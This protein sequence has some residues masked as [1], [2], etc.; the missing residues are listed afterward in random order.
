MF[1][2]KMK[3]LS[4]TFFTLLLLFGTLN[5]INCHKMKKNSDSN[6]WNKENFNS[7]FEKSEQNKL[8]K[9]GHDLIKDI[10]L[11]TYDPFSI[12]HNSNT[13][14]IQ[15]KHT[16]ISPK[17]PWTNIK[18]YFDYYHLNQS[19]DRKEITE[20]QHK[21]IYNVME[22]SLNVISE[23]VQVQS[24]NVRIFPQQYMTD[25]K[26]NPDIITNGVM[27]DLAICVSAIKSHSMAYAYATTLLNGNYRPLT[28]AVVWN[29]DIF[30]RDN[31]LEF[32][33]VNTALHELLHVMGFNYQLF[34]YFVDE[35]WQFLPI[36]KIVKKNAKGKD[37]IITPR[38]VEATR[39]HY[40]CSTIE[41]LELEDDGGSGTVGS[42]WEERIMSGEVMNGMD[43]KEAAL[44]EMT[45]ALLEDSGWYKTKKFT[46]G[47]FMFGRK[48][49]CEFLQ[50]KCVTEHGT[51]FKNE[52]CLTKN[53]SGCS[54]NRRWKSQCHLQEKDASSVANDELHFH[55][56]DNQ[57]KTV[58]LGSSRAFSDNCPVGTIFSYPHDSLY[59]SCSRGKID[60]FWNGPVSNYER[61]SNNG[62][63][64]I[65]NVRDKMYS[66]FYSGHSPYI[67][68]CYDFKCDF[69]KKTINLQINLKSFECP[70][71]GGI[72]DID[73]PNI[74]GNIV[75]PDFY[76]LC[77]QTEKCDS[78]LECVNKKSLR[79]EEPEILNM[80]S[81]ANMGSTLDKNMKIKKVKGY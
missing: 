55:Y 56:I 20:Q 28:G 14:F 40:G 58:T 32:L 5:L 22:K 48:K 31:G 19:K 3:I 17:L 75:C 69:N 30:T 66:K 70:S 53:E 15:I 1:K 43:T 13:E 21:S 72:I 35:N 7:L 27:A 50:D 77:N 76:F 18:I 54:T 33:Y 4:S 6:K 62:A 49:Q 73:D 79:I 41:G 80:V 57:G 63:C 2:Q 39:I 81:L 74:V 24:F 61:I 38:V 47:L 11:E 8:R 52:Y 42:H 78:I 65:T 26:W 67:S 37:M 71:R 10:R 12:K 44:S 29:P 59:F 46:G 23:L 36:E 68:G 9:C 64:F 51:K 25:C 45:L 16:E 34:S 60:K